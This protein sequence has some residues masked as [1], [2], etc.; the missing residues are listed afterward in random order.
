METV[1]VAAIVAAGVSSIG[2]FIN[3]AVARKVR[4]AS[5]DQLRFRAALKEA[6]RSIREIKA[7]CSEAEKLRD[8]CWQVLTTVCGLQKHRDDNQELLALS[9]HEAPFASACNAFFQAFA[10]V[11]AGISD[12]TVNSMRDLRQQCKAEAEEVL[13]AL[14]DLPATVRRAPRVV[15][16]DDTLYSLRLRLENLLSN[17]DR[18]FFT[19][20]MARDTILV[21]AWTGRKST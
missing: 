4:A 10:I 2:L 14:N 11:Q 19:V 9:E 3:L 6:E 8:A 13:R 7:F 5:A 20:L 12:S 21:D 17:L 16:F 18:L 1:L 15:S